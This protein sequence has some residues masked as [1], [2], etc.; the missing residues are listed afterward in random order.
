MA[1]TITLITSPAKD[2]GRC[3]GHGI[4]SKLLGK[5]QL[6]KAW[7]LCRFKSLLSPLIRVS[8]ALVSLFSSWYRKEEDIL[9]VETSFMY[10]NVVHLQCKYP[11]KRVAST[12]FLGLLLCLLFLKI[13]RLKKSYLQRYIFWGGS[14]TPLHFQLLCLCWS[15]K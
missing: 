15:K 14:S 3:W 5:A 9:I 6:T 10:I 4:Y 12:R 8:G 11:C 7:L 1:H 13:T 2:K